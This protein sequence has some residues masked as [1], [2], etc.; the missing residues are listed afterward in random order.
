M[1]YSKAFQR[2]AKSLKS[3]EYDSLDSGKEVILLKEYKNGSE[4]AFNKIVKSYLRFVIFILKD[5]KIPENLDIMDI[6]QEGN[7]GFITGLK[8]FDPFK[9]DCRISTYCVFWVKFY[10][11]KALDAN[12]KYNKAFYD[13]PENE[14]IEQVAGLEDKVE[15]E[16]QGKICQEINEYIL[17]ILNPREQYIIKAYYGLEYP[18]TQKTLQE[19]A[20]ICHINIERVRQIKDAALNKLNKKTISDFVHNK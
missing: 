5:F 2:Y 6:I 7:L 17:T 15:D 9:Y 19:I 18:F 16:I 4:I 8:K 12:S 1:N 10:I 13:L 20:L 14:T 11:R 3:K